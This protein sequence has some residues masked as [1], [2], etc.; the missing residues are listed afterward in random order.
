MQSNKRQ[1]TLVDFDI[2][3]TDSLVP[4]HVKKRQKSPIF[5][6][7]ETESYH[8]HI[9]EENIAVKDEQQAVRNNL[10]V[11]DEDQEDNSEAVEVI[12][13]VTKPSPKAQDLRLALS[14]NQ[15]DA[16]P[17]PVRKQKNSF[18]ESLTTVGQKLVSV[19]EVGEEQ[20]VLCP[21]CGIVLTKLEIHER[22]AHCDHCIEKGAAPSKTRTGRRIPRLPEVKKVRFKNHVI[23]VDGFNFQSDPSIHQYFLS[24]FHADHYMGVKKSW[25]QGTIYCSKVTADLLIYKFKVPQDRII[26]LPAEVTIQISSN[27]SVICFDA[28]HCPGAFVFLFREFGG[29]NE[30]VQWVLHTGDFRSNNDLITKIIE[31]TSGKPIDKVYLDTTYMYPSYHFPLQ[32]SVLDVTGEFAFKLRDVG[33][34]KLFGDRQSSIM[35]FVSNS[36]RP[37]HL[38]KYVFVVGTYTIGKEKLAIAIAERLQTKIFVARDTARHCIIQ[39]YK[40]KFPEGM[41]THDI[42][43]ACVHL[44]SLRTLSSKETLQYYFKPISHIYEDM[45]AFAPTGWSFKNGGRFIKLHE[46]L[47]QKIEHTVNLLKDSTVDNLDPSSIHKQYKRDVRFQ[48]FQVPY[49]EHSSF[50]DLANFCVRL[51][52]VKIIP[53]VNTH[54]DYM[55]SQMR[56]WFKAW[57]SVHGQRTA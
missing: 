19:T 24:H 25:D 12:S 20:Q 56:E 52:W 3:K 34:K 50:K 31:H 26:A 9:L 6:D 17:K 47:E 11:A 2:P 16:K 30:T 13:D 40:D 35:S 1:R 45:V 23:N 5:I 21:V 48:V 54:D 14:G 57:K 38:Y 46:T 33:L 42:T 49:S 51:P 44:V 32:K 7:L 43:K 28:N 37:R 8:E 55:V 27:V 39:T 53:T 22:E 10:F 29:D 36:L 18:T 4:R 15:N 41:I